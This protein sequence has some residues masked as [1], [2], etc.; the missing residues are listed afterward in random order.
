[1]QDNEN[2]VNFLDWTCS[3]GEFMPP[4]GLRVQHEFDHEPSYVVGADDA[5]VCTVHPTGDRKA[6]DLARLIAD[7][8]EMEQLLRQAMA[9]VQD[10]YFGIH[11]SR[12]LATTHA[13]DAKL[14]VQARKFMERHALFPS[15]KS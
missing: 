1:M 13:R 5:E 11:T 8:P 6:S 15:P 3:M 4:S 7:L 2:E 9:A 10:Y 14:L 12:L